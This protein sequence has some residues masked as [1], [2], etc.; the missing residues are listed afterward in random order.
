M[1]I[2][3]QKPDGSQF[4]TSSDA[5]DVSGIVTSNKITTSYGIVGGSASIDAA[6]VSYTDS[7]GE[8]IWIQTKTWFSQFTFAQGDRINLS[9]LAMPTSFAGGTQATTDFI[10]FLTRPQG[11]IVVDIGF[12]YVLPASSTVGHV[13]DGTDTSGGANKLGY[14]NFIIIRNSFSDPSTGSVAIQPFGGSTAT[15]NTLTAALNTAPAVLK[16][17][18]INMSHQIQIIFRVITRDMDSKTHLRPDNM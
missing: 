3:I 17:R 7:S 13:R 12:N 4:S 1:T 16:G 8:F 2:Q 10:S 9:N 6:G 18:L 5:I 14:S 11:H 15:N